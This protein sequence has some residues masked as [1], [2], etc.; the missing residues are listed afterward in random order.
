MAK[1]KQQKQQNKQPDK[2]KF[3]VMETESIAEC[4]QRMDKEGYR[5]VRRMEE[6]IFEEKEENGTTEVIPVRQLVIFEGKKK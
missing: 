4:L 2:K 1:K 5:P 6:P 3:E